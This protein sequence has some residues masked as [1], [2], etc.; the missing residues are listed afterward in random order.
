MQWKDKFLSIVTN[1]VPI[2]TIQDTNSPPWIDGEVRHLIRKKYIALRKYRKNKTADRKIKL[3]TL[4]QQ[5]KSSPAKTIM[6]PDDSTSF[7]IF[8]S[9]LSDITVSEEEVAKHL[10][11]LDP[12]K[13]IGAGGIPAR[14][15][16]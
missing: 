7:L 4:C 14:I 16:K 3:R 8:P 12:S 11:H 15:L 10:Y 13:A 5:I 9:Q 1:F 6:N 2:K